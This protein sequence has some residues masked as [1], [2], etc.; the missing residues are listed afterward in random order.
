MF[1]NISHV[2]TFGMDKVWLGKIVCTI[3]VCFDGDGSALMG[4]IP[5]FQSLLEEGA[6]L[7]SKYN[8]YFTKAFAEWLYGI[9]FI[10][11]HHTTSGD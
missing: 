5:G 10:V 6:Y 1:K 11:T 8:Y 4:G 2:L 3:K 7:A 9:S